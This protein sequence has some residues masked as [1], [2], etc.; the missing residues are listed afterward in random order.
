MMDKKFYTPGM[1]PTQG[2]GVTGN[3]IKISKGD[4]VSKVIPGSVNHKKKMRNKSLSKT[5]HYKNPLRGFS[6]DHQ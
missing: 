6:P 4:M 2:I 1:M 3:K 5:A